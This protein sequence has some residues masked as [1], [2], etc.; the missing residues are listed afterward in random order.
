M[1]WY[2]FKDGVEQRIP[3]ELLSDPWV[4]VYYNV[5]KDAKGKPLRNEKGKLETTSP[6]MM[7]G[8][9]MCPN[10]EKLQGALVRPIVKY[11]SYRNRLGVLNGWL[12]NDRLAYDGR[13]TAG[14]SGITNTHRIKHSVIANLPKAED[15]ILLGKEMRELFICDKGM[16]YIN[17]DASQLEARLE[18]SYCYKYEGGK[19]Y[20]EDMLKGD[21]HSKTAKYVWAK[22]LEAYDISD[23]L[24]NKE[25]PGFKPFRSKAKSVRY[26][27]SYGA[28]AP[29]LAK[30]LGET[31]E[32]GE[33]IHRRFWESSAPLAAFRDKLEM[34]WEMHGDKKWLIG[35]DGRKIYTRAKH[36]LTN[37]ILQNAGAVVMDL[38]NAWMDKQL[39]GITLDSDK[40]PCYTFKGGKAQRL[41][42]YH[43]EASWQATPDIAEEVG[44][45]GVESIRWA[46]RYLKLNIPLDGAYK[47]GT[48]WATH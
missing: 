15:D 42:V 27:C 6:K 20:A 44:M 3:K 45:L 41:I 46:G 5:R 34:F 29:K 4:P 28:G 48:S 8:K 37:V 2:G 9:M 47:L 19:Q 39:G 38:A 17:Y 7:E 31:K 16:V 26:G 10:L 33:E 22:E 1:P 30:M 12:N 18:A 23:L 21:I 11:L 13:L 36:S 43:D 24:F 32:R 40:K 25:D 14:A 35:I